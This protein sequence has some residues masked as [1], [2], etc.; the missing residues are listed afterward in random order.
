MFIAVAI[1]VATAALKDREYFKQCVEKVKSERGRMAEELRSLGFD[2]PQSE[3]NFLLARYKGGNAGG[4]YEEL[5]KQNIYVRYFPYPGLEDKL[6]IS[7]GTAEQNDR[8]VAAL[9]EILS[10]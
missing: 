5:A 6:R 7:I 4:V 9:K 2:M 10:K 3:S 8:L 1:A